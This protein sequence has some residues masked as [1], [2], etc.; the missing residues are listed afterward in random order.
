MMMNEGER[1]DLLHRLLDSTVDVDLGYWLAGVLVRF[2]GLPYERIKNLAV[3]DIEADGN[4]TWLCA[5]DEPLLLPPRV[6]A[7]LELK[8]RT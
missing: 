1:I 7:V 3:D 4:D 6:A 5:A 8:S 2:Y